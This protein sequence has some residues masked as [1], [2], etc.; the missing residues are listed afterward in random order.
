MK[1]ITI[2][3]IVAL[4][5]L[6]FINPSKTGIISTLNA[7]AETAQEIINI[8]LEGEVKYT[9]Y[10]E[11]LCFLN[12]GKLS[13]IN[14]NGKEVFS[15]DIPVENVNLSSDNY[16]DVLNK[17]SNKIYSIDDKG[18]IIFSSETSKDGFLYKSINEYVF[19]DVIRSNG[20]EVIKILNESG[21]VSKKITIEG[22]VANVKPL[23]ENILVSYISITD[24]V[25][26]NLIVYD[27]NGNL[28]SQSKLEGII[29]DI[30]IMNDN[31]YLVLDNKII[32]LDKELNT[33]I[34]IDLKDIISI[35]NNKDKIFV[36]DNEGSIGYIQDNEYHNIKT[37]E[38][39]I[40]I[41]GMESTYILYSDRTLY[42]DKL[43][44]IIT[45][46][47]EIKDVEYISGKSIAVIFDR[48][49]K[50]FNVE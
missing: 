19:V 44:E 22:K 35:S 26:N 15:K 33:K 2:L 20:K 21:W 17:N 12:N 38:K 25:Y 11:L 10:K 13:A 29:L 32:I 16:I 9:K 47:D 37:K 4:L 24:K 30:I 3:V 48:Y 39:N 5:L 6:I 27:S 40:S 28:K 31:V 50:I 8:D 23:D 43:K 14:E 46:E 1:K 36:K 41:E 18:E 45:F 42:N 7:S 34:Q 49:I